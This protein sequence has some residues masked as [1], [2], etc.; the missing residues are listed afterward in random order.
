[1]KAC[2][3]VDGVSRKAVIACTLSLLD[4]LYAAKNS[5]LAGHRMGF[6]LWPQEYR[7]RGR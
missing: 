5:P 4:G 7:R 2:V 1:M 3:V 6:A